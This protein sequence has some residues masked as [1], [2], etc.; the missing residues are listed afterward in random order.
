MSDFPMIQKAACTKHF[1]NYYALFNYVLDHGT[2][3]ASTQ[4]V[5]NVRY[6]VSPRSFN[7]PVNRFELGNDD[8]IIVPA[9]R[10]NGQKFSERYA[11]CE[12]AWYAYG[13]RDPQPMIDAGFSVWKNMA[14][15]N[16]LVN[17]NYGYQ[18][19][20]N[21]PVTPNA[22]AIAQHLLRKLRNSDDQVIEHTIPLL[23]RD[24]EKSPNDVPCNVHITITLRRLDNGQVAI[25]GHSHARSIDLVYGLPYDSFMLQL[26]VRS[27]MDKYRVQAAEFD[28]DIVADAVFVSFDIANCHIYHDTIDDMT[29]DDGELQRCSTDS[30]Y[31]AFRVEQVQRALV[32]DDMRNLSLPSNKA[33]FDKML[34]REQIAYL[35]LNTTLQQHAIDAP[36]YVMHKNTA[37]AFINMNEFDP[38]ARLALK[39]ALRNRFNFIG[40]NTHGVTLLSG[41]DDRCASYRIAHDVLFD[42]ENRKH[43]Y[44]IG[45]H[46]SAKRGVESRPVIL[47]TSFDPHEKIVYVW[48][49]V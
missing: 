4:A 48:T 39:E 19:R 8:V 30:M 43:S 33:A 29:S 1:D 23:T 27:V 32:I 11:L 49:I 44:V 36:A 25:S 28:P 24:N 31:L 17:S 46:D 37:D 38:V 12:A 2:Q 21:T 34:S 5:Y 14:D 13:T 22:Y 7:V 9:H 26:L 18:W 20:N 3:H 35:S 6:N 45:V 41:D 10:G 42:P 15:H 40:C 16:G 47:M